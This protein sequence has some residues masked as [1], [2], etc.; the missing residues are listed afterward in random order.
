MLYALTSLPSTA[1]YLVAAG[2]FT[3]VL[4]ACG[5]GGGALQAGGFTAALWGLFKKMEKMFK[6]GVEAIER[7]IMTAAG[8]VAAAIPQLGFLMAYLQQA[9]DFLKGAAPVVL[10]LLAFWVF[11]K[12]R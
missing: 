10:L 6:N 11:T 5:G 8:A 9:F 4:A 3:A 1:Q 2:V 12:I 7:V